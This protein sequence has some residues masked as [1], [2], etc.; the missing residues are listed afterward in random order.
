MRNG[1]YAPDMSALVALAEE[2]STCTRCPLAEGRTQVVFGMGDPDADLMFVG[3]GP[4]AEE[5]KQGLPF[6]GRSG[7]LLDRLILEEMG[8]TRRATVYIANVVK[9][10]PPGN[11]DPRPDE[12]EAC[13]PYL[14]RQLDLIAPT[15]VVTLGSFATKLLLETNEGDHQAAGPHLPVRAPACWSRRCIPRASCV[16]APSRWRRCAPTSCGPSS[17]SP[18]PVAAACRT[19]AH[20]DDHDLARTDRGRRGDP[21][22]GCRAGRSRPRPATSPARRRPGRRQDRVRPGLRRGARASTDQITSPTFTLVHDYAGRLA[23]HH[24][25][26]YRLEHLQRGR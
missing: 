2:A 7:K 16:A 20:H 14:E 15:V 10:R 6:V 4:G 21:G 22:A 11:R 12:I 19:D 17:P 25:D 18:R 13:R 26:V 24:L 1:H 23:L 9:C 5:D 8:L 3:E